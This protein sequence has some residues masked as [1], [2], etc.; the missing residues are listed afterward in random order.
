[1]AKGLQK[2]FFLC[3]ST[4]KTTKTRAEKDPKTSPFKTFNSLFDPLAAQR[5]PKT[6]NSLFDP[7]ATTASAKFTNSSDYPPDFTSKSSRSCCS[8]NFTEI[9]PN[10]AVLPT[11]RRFFFSPAKSNSLIDDIGIVD[12]PL[13]NYQETSPARPEIL[14]GAEAVKTHS[15]DPYID[16]RQSMAEMIQSRLVAGLVMDWVY[17][18]ELLSCYLRL[19]EKDSHKFIMGAFADLVVNSVFENGRKSEFSGEFGADR[20]AGI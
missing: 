4:P 17:L 16:F 2:S 15:S 11:S 1:M 5:D 3:I 14:G 19:N 18:K 7:L 9:P 6:F 20:M 12:P 8:S 13:E 10:L